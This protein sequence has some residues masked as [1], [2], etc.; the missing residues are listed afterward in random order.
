MLCYEYLKQKGKETIIITTDKN[1]K[2]TLEQISRSKDLSY[3]D[4]IQNEELKRAFMRS[5]EII[6]EVII[7]ISF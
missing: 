1:L 2:N 7:L 4:F 3:E 6:G 5:L